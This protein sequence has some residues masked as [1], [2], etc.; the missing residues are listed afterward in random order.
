MVELSDRQSL[1]GGFRSKTTSSGLGPFFKKT[2]ENANN[3][4]GLL[5]SSWN[6]CC[7]VSH[8]VLIQL[9]RRV[10]QGDDNFNLLCCL[11]ENKEK[12][13]DEVRE[14]SGS[15]DYL[16]SFSATKHETNQQH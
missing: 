3:L 4:H 15:E 11:P 14:H 16:T 10:D 6:C 7:E 1:R 2:R 5:K 9:E 12:M 8:K 13:D